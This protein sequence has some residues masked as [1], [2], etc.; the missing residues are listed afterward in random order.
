MS[1]EIRTPMNGVIGTTDLL[2]RTPLEYEQHDLVETIRMSSRALLAIITDILDFS[3]IDSGS[4]EF[5]Q[6][7][8]D[9]RQCVESS[10]DVVA[11]VAAEKGLA[12]YYYLEPT[13]AQ[14]VI[15]DEL[16]LRQVL[17]NLLSNAV[18]F[19]ERGQ[20]LVSGK[21][22]PAQNGACLLQFEVEDTG[23]GIAADKF[24]LIFSSFSQV[25]V[26]HTR[27]YGG[28]GLGL[29][30]SK[31]LCERQGGRLW[32]ESAPGVGSSFQFT[33]QVQLPLGEADHTLLPSPPIL[34]GKH[35]AVVDANPTGRRIL[36]AYLQEW[37]VCAHC[38]GG[39]D[40]LQTALHNGL[41]LD[42]LI[43]CL[44]TSLDD[45]A[46]L[47]R[48]LQQV[49]PHWPVLV[50]ATI[51]NVQLRVDVP[52]LTG[53]TLLFQP[54]RPQD[55]LGKLLSLTGKV[56]RT[57]VHEAATPLDG[58]FSKKFPAT[59]LV[60]EDNAVNQ[61]VLLRLLQ[62]LGYQAALAVDGADAVEQARCGDFSVIF[63][64]VQMPIMDGLEATRQIRALSSGVRNGMQ[65]HIVA[66]TAAATQEDRNQCL[67]AGMD[68][69]VTKPTSL[70]RIAEAIQRMVRQRP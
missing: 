58:S 48:R 64:D 28:T 21:A 43:C 55:L 29:A 4:L 49:E 62:K 67:L 60:V 33:W 12:L 40:E 5:E 35:V 17:V 24:D 13:V 1:H 57:P 59:I 66:M 14:T 46:D 63:M 9:V 2:L 15:G 10:L 52:A 56:T 26:S 30:I 11:A 23:I 53:H 70:E 51:N 20:I 39:C 32:V 6:K 45:A 41:Q 36:A 50:Y 8:F 68:D 7:S 61:K 18:K 16:R 44:P 69:F 38:L 42:A 34:A 19:T 22:H 54:F 37:G 47:I 31:R 65:P 27:R 25:D 3:K